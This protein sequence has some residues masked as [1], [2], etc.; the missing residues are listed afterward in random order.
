[1]EAA[2]AACEF[3]VDRV[4]GLDLVDFD[5]VDLDPS[6]MGRQREMTLSSY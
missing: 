1:M 4:H 3:Q 2:E 6:R 5:L